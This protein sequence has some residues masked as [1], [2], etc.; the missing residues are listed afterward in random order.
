MASKALILDRDGVVNVETNYLYKIEEFEFIDGIIPLCLKF[1]QMNFKII[2]ITNQAGIAR[3]LYTERDYQY[4]T[5]W[6]ISKFKEAGVKISE[7]YHCPHHPEFTGPCDCR[8]P[9]PGMFLT[10][11]AEFD[12]DFSSSIN[13]GDKETDI[14]AGKA[15]GVAT[16]IHFKGDRFDPMVEPWKSLLIV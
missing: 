1:Q 2:I 12:L 15:A 16:N 8:K 10:A 14:A 6:M 4:L 3:A 13:V 5:E 11:K 7:V 9:K